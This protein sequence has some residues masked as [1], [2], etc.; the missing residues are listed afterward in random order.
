[1][2][3]PF[4]VDRRPDKLGSYVTVDGIDYPLVPGSEVLGA[5]LNP[6]SPAS[7]AGTSSRITSQ[8]HAVRVWDDFTQGIGFKDD[9]E[10]HG[11]IAYG[12]LDL[13]I[14]DEATVPT[15]A[16]P[17]GTTSGFNS[18]AMLPVRCVFMNNADTG[19]YTFFCYANSNTGATIRTIKSTNRNTVTTTVATENVQGVA[20]WQGNWY[21]LTSDTASSNMRLYKITAVN[22]ITG[23]ITFTL[24][25]T[26]LNTYRGLVGYDNKL[27]TYDDAGNQFVQLTSTPT[28][29]VYLGG[30][31]KSPFNESALQLFVWTDKSG[32][33]DALY[34]LTSARILV[35]D[36]EGQQWEPFFEFARLWPAV[37]GYCHV[38]QRDNT[39]L[40]VPLHLPNTSS[41]TGGQVNDNILAF[42]P[43][44][45]DNWAVNKEKAL[46]TE[47]TFT[48]GVG[49]IASVP[50]VLAS[51]SHWTFAFMYAPTVGATSGLGSTVMA[52]N[53]EGGWTIVF[54]GNVVASAGSFSYS[55]IIGGGYGGGRLLVITA[56]GR[57]WDLSMPDNDIAHPRGSYENGNLHV[58]FARSGRIYNG[59][60]NVTKLASHLEVKLKNALAGTEQVELQLNTWDGVNMSGF[61]T[62]GNLASA[63][64]LLVSYVLP[65]ARP[66]KYAEWKLLLKSMSPG[67]PPVVESVSLYYTYWQQNHFAYS[68]TIDLSA[69]TWA[70]E[71][72]NNIFHG[73]SRSWLQQQLLTM[74]DGQT[75]HTF[76][77][78]RWDMRESVAK[79]DILLSR[80]EVA[81]NG[82]G[83]YPCTAR[84][85]EQ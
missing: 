85:L 37:N 63:G 6:F 65:N 10:E 23:V 36:E 48:A 68:F 56:D 41:A 64:A 29:V 61:T 38:N 81:D 74:I 75:Y 49:H 17:L 33:R 50:V 78:N 4:L 43:G 77:Y 39:L 28:W 25:L 20:Q 59:Q 22:P 72:P 84:D 1:M 79:A 40:F 24:I 30:L 18:T 83:V 47:E 76:S 15:D 82:G 34:T 69:E 7:Q 60:R 58:Y 11:G 80:R 21:F 32:S 26:T 57:W 27:I 31:D 71:Y 46:P 14:P 51:G 42:S 52:R 12:N 2:V 73:H 44:T 16:Q 19:T 9:N 5:P 45:V 35:Y 8:R 3:G 13:R 70:T 54:D 62:S 53:K 55:P 66:Y 67:S